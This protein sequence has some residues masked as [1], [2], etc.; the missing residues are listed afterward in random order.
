[1]FAVAEVRGATLRASET[2]SEDRR[3]VKTPQGIA[4]A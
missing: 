4:E 2:V 1:M 3:G